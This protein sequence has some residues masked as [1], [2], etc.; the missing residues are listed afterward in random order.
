MSSPYGR[1]PATTESK[2]KNTNITAAPMLPDR[3]MGMTVSTDTEQVITNAD[4]VLQ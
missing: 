2:A 4:T 1:S 3:T